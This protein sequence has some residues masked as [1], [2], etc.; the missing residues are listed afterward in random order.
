M[1]DPWA[2]FTDTRPHPHVTP[3]WTKDPYGNSWQHKDAGTSDKACKSADH[4]GVEFP[5]RTVGGGKALKDEEEA[6]A[7]LKE[8]YIRLQE[9]QDHPE[10]EGDVSNR[11][12][13]Y[14]RALQDLK[15]ATHMREETHR[16][17]EKETAQKKDIQ[18]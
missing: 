12:E 8:A 13:D 11:Q 1:V 4:Q 7:K 2:T 14:T 15:K 3:P 5:P 18:H 6:E 16:K 9:A 10:G 17:A